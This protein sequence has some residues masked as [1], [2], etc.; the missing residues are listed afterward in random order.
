[1]FPHSKNNLRKI[2]CINVKSAPVIILIKQMCCK[3]QIGIDIDKRQTTDSNWIIFPI[4]NIQKKSPRFVLLKRCP[5]KFFK[6]H[7]KT[8][9]PVSFL[10]KLQAEACNLIKKETLAQV[11]SCKFCEISKNTFSYGTLPVADSEYCFLVRMHTS[12]VITAEQKPN[13]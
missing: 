8:P 6:I 1:M 3:H 7:R 13:K 12:F 11:L 4:Q 5:Q 10:I 2:I 9:V